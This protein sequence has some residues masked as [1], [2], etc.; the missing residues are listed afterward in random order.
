MSV[1]GPSPFRN[2][3]DWL[4]WRSTGAF[5]DFR[6]ATCLAIIRTERFNRSWFGYFRYNV[7]DV[8]RVLARYKEHVSYWNISIEVIQRELA[9]FAIELQRD[10]QEIFQEFD[11][12]PAQRFLPAE[13]VADAFCRNWRNHAMSKPGELHQPGLEPETGMTMVL[14]FIRLLLAGSSFNVS[15]VIFTLPS[16]I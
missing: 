1:E 9:E 11:K 16:R 8:R 6:I 2:W 13:I 14:Y 4:I 5:G 3:G 10:P 15:I 12:L 7:D